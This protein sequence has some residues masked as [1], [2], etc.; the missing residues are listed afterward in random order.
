[1]GCRR[2]GGKGVVSVFLAGGGGVAFS[3]V[4]C[5]VVWCC[6]FVLVACWRRRP[7]S[8]ARS[9]LKGWSEAVGD[10]TFLYC[11]YSEGSSEAVGAIGARF[12]FL[13]GGPCSRTLFC[14]EGVFF[15]K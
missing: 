13:A 9:L 6:S 8:L 1:M 10:G 5:P 14:L 7:R 3:G 2:T 12:C 15:F 11:L 4:T